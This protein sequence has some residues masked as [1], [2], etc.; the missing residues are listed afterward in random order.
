MKYYHSKGESILDNSA[1]TPAQRITSRTRSGRQSAVSA[2]S[3]GFGKNGKELLLRVFENF[4]NSGTKGKV[5]LDDRLRARNELEEQGGH[6][7]TIW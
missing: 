2:R 1:A 6:M 3:H 5:V 7:S 4:N